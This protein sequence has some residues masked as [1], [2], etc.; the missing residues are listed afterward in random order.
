MSLCT[1]STRICLDLILP[2][3]NPRVATCQHVHVSLRYRIPSRHQVHFIGCCLLRELWFGF[4]PEFATVY[5]AEVCSVYFGQLCG[6]LSW[7]MQTVFF[8]ILTVLPKLRQLRRIFLVSF[9]RMLHSLSLALRICQHRQFQQTGSFRKDHSAAVEVRWCAVLVWVKMLISSWT[10]KK[11]LMMFSTKIV[12]SGNLLH[13]Y[14]K[15]PIEIVDFPIKNGGS[16]HSFLYVYQRVYPLVIIS[17]KNF[18]QPSQPG[19][20]QAAFP[21][22]S[23]DLSCGPWGKTPRRQNY[24]TVLRHETRFEWQGHVLFKICQSAKSIQII[25]NP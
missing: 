4:L 16:S 18:S 23:L 1:T 22:A 7:A 21:L 12:P 24:R 5:A 14:W 20:S 19:P 3:Q 13:S 9:Q 17:V 11:L 6:N 2:N 8:G 10:H 15:W 25:P